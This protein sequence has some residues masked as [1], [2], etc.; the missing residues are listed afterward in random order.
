MTKDGLGGDNVTQFTLR[1]ASRHPSET[2]RTHNEELLKGLDENARAMYSSL[3]EHGSVKNNSRLPKERAG[4]LVIMRGYEPEEFGPYLNL[5]PEH[6]TKKE[7]SAFLIAELYLKKRG[8]L[9]DSGEL[10]E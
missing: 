2:V 3:K 7:S 8:L 4:I 5:G 9:R 6:W 10:K 1:A